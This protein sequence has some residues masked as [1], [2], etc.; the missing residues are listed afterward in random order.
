MTTE[1]IQHPESNTHAT[2]AASI[3]FNCFDFRTHVDG[4]AVN[5]IEGDLGILQSGGVSLRGIPILCPFPN[6][7]REGRY[8][9]AGATYELGP[10]DVTYDGTGNAIH[11][12]CHD[13]P[14]RVVERGGHFVT[15]EFQLSVDAPRRAALWP[16]DFSIRMRYEVGDAK[17]WAIATV[18][19][20]GRQPMPFGLGFHPYFQLPLGADSKA[21]RCT[22]QVPV[23]QQWDLNDCLPSGSK[24]EISDEL[25]LSDGV[26]Y[27]Q[28]KLDHLFTGVESAGGAIETSIIDEPAGLQLTH[29]FDST[30]PHVVIYTPPGRESV[31]IEPYTCISDAINLHEAVPDSG[32]LVLEPAESFTGRFEIRIGPVIV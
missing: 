8:S 21:T 27:G 29:R 25:P 28:A 6:R 11:G 13:R 12:F 1:T 24:S 3:G 16:S 19:N 15:G 5:V 2:I 20:M 32:L 23:R 10:D 7:I 22:V 14:W 17:L 18:T 9:W 30:F 26:Y 31:C 4:R